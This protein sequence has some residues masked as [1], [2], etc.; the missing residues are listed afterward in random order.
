M[1]RVREITQRDERRPAISR[2]RGAFLE[3]STRDARLTAFEHLVRFD[4]TAFTVQ[5]SAALNEVIGAAGREHGKT[6]RD[7]R[8]EYD[9]LAHPP[10]DNDGFGA[11]LARH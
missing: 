9:A 3:R 4:V 6:R 1:L 7:T 11:K 10:K 5:I 8:Y 2:V